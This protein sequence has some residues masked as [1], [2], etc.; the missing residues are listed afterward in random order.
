M[1]ISVLGS[2]GTALCQINSLRQAFSSLGYEHTPDFYDESVSFVFVGNPPY[3]KYKEI[4]KT[5]KKI[6]LNVLDIPWH[7]PEIEEFIKSMD[8]S[9]SIADKVT[10]IS[11]TVAN[12]ISET[13]GI[14]PDVIYYPMKNVKRTGDKEIKNLKAA[15]VGRVR[16]KN[17]YAASAIQ[18]LLNAGIKEDEIAIVGPEYFGVGRNMGVVNDETLE[19]IYNSVDYVVML[20]RVAGIGLPAIEGACCGAIP[21]VAS[22]LTTLDEFWSLSPLYEKYKKLKSITDIS[23]LISEIEN[24][25]DLKENLK[26]ECC[27]YANLFLKNKFNPKEVAKKIINSYESIKK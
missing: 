27:A 20:D 7:V 16:D 19:K 4:F 26:I 1:K 5:D 18:A 17:K 9:L 22:H 14:N 8:Q 12:D 2:D 6:I 15:I 13:F 10:T 23:N 11:K 21:I 25:Y 24:N 3:Q